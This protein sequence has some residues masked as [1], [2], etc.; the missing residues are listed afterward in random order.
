MT[1]TWRYN[2]VSTNGAGPGARRRGEMNGTSAAEV[3]ASL[4]RVGWQVLDLKPVRLRAAGDKDALAALW[5]GH[6]RSRRR[7][8]R[9]EIFDSAATMLESGVPVLQAVTILISADTARRS[10]RRTMLTQ[11]RGT[12]QDGSSL[13]HAM[14]AHPA[15]FEP[16]EIAIVEA[17]QQSGELPTV[18]RSLAQRNE[19][20]NELGQRLIAALS[21]PVILCIVGLG[22]VVFLSTR[23]LPG[24]V[25]IL[26]DAGVE[27]PALSTRVMAV[28]QTLANWW[29]LL[30][31]AGIL[32][33]GAVLVGPTWLERHGIALPRW[34]SRLRPRVS[35]RMALSGLSLGVAELIETGIPVGDALRIVAPTLRCRSLRRQVIEVAARID[36]GADLADA[37]DAGEWFDAEFRQLVEVGQASGEL[38]AVLRRLGDRYGR[39]ARRLI[40]RLTAMLEPAVILT[41]AFLVG[42]V[43]MSAVLPLMRLQ[44][45]L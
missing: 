35:R 26:T 4:R 43:V 32:A 24:L 10:G 16:T 9:A 22:V 18:L 25:E 40:D 20:A 15:W 34:C 37:L 44:E 38:A 39:A 31:V 21:Y 5:F 33:V 2:A 41:L 7:E 27:A 42:V 1:T 36:R 11:L 3:R 6:L 8:S 13:A 17:G 29:P 45:I 14:A 28:G 30:G 12:L 19:R 23:T